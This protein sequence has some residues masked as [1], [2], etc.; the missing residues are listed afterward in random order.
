L[1]AYDKP[2]DF[3]AFSV[4]HLYFVVFSL[5]PSSLGA[6]LPAVGSFD[7]VESLAVIIVLGPWRRLGQGVVV[8]LLARFD[9]QILL[10]GRHLGPVERIVA[11]ERGEEGCRRRRRPVGEVGDGGRRRHR[12]GGGGR[13]RAGGGRRQGGGGDEPGRVVRHQRRSEQRLRQVRHEAGGEG[14]TLGA[15]EETVAGP[16]REERAGRGLRFAASQAVLRR[17]GRR[18]VL[19]WQEFFCNTTEI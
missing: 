10:S 6:R 2:S 7:G 11:E 15:G 18:E 16:A 14:Q 12:A 4:T 9:D 13:L 1:I 5:S 17:L 19:E 8:P 3:T